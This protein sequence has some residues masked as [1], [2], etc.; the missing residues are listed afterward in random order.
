MKLCTLTVGLTTVALLFCTVMV[1]SQA[2]ENVAESAQHK[3]ALTNANQNS[4]TGTTAVKQK[5]VAPVALVDINSANKQEL[6]KLPGISAAEADKI[7]A[8][9]PYGSKAWLVTEKI[10]PGITYEA[11]KYKIVCKITKADMVKI[12]AKAAALKEKK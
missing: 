5:K 11:I 6:M 1:N 3:A 8:G 7:I 4:V 2:T 9:R 12:K 10:V